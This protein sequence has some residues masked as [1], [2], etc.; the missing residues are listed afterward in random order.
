MSFEMLLVEQCYFSTTAMAT[1]LYARMEFRYIFCYLQFQFLN[2]TNTVSNW[3]TMSK[4]NKNN[5][6]EKKQIMHAVFK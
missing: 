6:L 2:C 5:L 3:P 1:P 4:W